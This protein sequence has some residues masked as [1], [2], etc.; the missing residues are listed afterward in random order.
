MSIAAAT[1]DSG[2]SV[3]VDRQHTERVI[4][5]DQVHQHFVAEVGGSQLTYEHKVLPYLCSSSASTGWRGGAWAWW[6]VG[7]VRARTPSLISV[8]V[9]GWLR[10][11]D[12]MVDGVF[13][14]AVRP[15]CL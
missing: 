8:L 1:G 15:L 14:D 9:P 7:V 12:M 2:H 6:V 11:G 4:V 13:C 10:S 3:H 5:P